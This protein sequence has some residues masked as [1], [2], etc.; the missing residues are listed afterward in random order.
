MSF[1]EWQPIYAAYGL[2]TF[3]VDSST[4]RPLVKNYLKAGCPYSNALAKKFPN[5]DALGFALGARSKITVL[6]CDSNDQR[7]LADAMKRRGGTPLIV[8]SG[9]GNFQAWYRH[10][11]EGRRI[12]PDARF[13]IDVLGDGFVV[14]PPSRGV[15]S[16]YQIIEGSLADL[17]KLP[18]LKNFA[19]PKVV[20][21]GNNL[22]PAGMRNNEL[23]RHCMRNAH[24]CDDEA[25]LLDVAETFVSH[26]EQPAGRPVTADE[27]RATVRKVLDY[28][29]RGENRFGQKG[30]WMPENITSLVFGDEDAF[31]LCFFLKQHNGAG[32]KF[33]IANHGVSEILGWHRKRLSQAR[34]RLL[35]LGIICQVRAATQNQPA[36]Y[37]WGSPL[38]GGREGERE[39]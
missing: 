25:A 35:A 37:V 32:S 29:A 18:P 22:I 38:Q 23:F 34:A 4:K 5:A 7:I 19:P 26:C 28:T 11:G 8:R 14:A 39:C 31:R 27:I 16:R 24:H 33:M 6:D 3:P 20:V 9:S 15:H 12:R 21:A 10:N 36:L 17:G 30:V 1:A 2:A 13:P